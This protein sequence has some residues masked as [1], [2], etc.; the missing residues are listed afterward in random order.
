VDPVGRKPNPERKP[1]LLDQIV[2]YLAEH[3]LGSASLRPLADALGISTYTLVY[4][5]GSKEQLVVEALEHADRRQ[6]AL[7]EEW[8]AD[9][10]EITTEELVR[11][12][13]RWA[14]EPHNL[15]VVRL[16]FEAITLSATDASMQ[17]QLVTNW[18]DAL[19]A[20]FL[21]AG[22]S[23]RDARQLATIFNA[24]FIGLILDLLATGDRRRLDGALEELL[25]LSDPMRRPRPRSAVGP[26]TRG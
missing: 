6:M 18:I 2:D 21:A 22:A 5:F 9:D 8:L 4:H 23:A 7:V 20:G 24:A 3:G 16:A 14:C 26:R 25:A 11:R 17:S 15:R 1:E 19:T 10:P 13:W 12:F